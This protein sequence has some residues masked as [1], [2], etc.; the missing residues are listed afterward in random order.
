[1][2]E[3]DLDSDEVLGYLDNCPTI[4]NPNQEDIDL[5][6]IGD[7]CDAYP[8]EPCDPVGELPPSTATLG[9]SQNNSCEGWSGVSQPG[10]NLQSAVLT[11][12]DLS[13]AN[14]DGALLSN[15][16]LIGANLANASLMNGQLGFANLN[17][18]IMTDCNLTSSNLAFASLDSANLTNADMSFAN[19]VDAKLVNADLKGADLS[20]ANLTAALYDES[21]VFPSGDIW[22]VPPWGLDG[23]VE[24]W[25]A[26]MIPVPEPS[27]GS[28]L[29]FG[30]MGLAG[31]WAMKRSD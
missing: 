10:D 15:A 3:I 31:L 29:L 7:A 18:A 6:L 4:P 13:F 12:A 22:D 25:N 21:T 1:M 9:A 27:A 19:L 16:T 14:L 11:K 17:S 26:G 5:D 23:G 28:L 24:P 8:N 2:P 20:S 30:V